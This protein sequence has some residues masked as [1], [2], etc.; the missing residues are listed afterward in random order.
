MHVTSNLAIL[1]NIK[2]AIYLC[3]DFNIKEKNL[4]VNKGE[5]K[6]WQKTDM[7]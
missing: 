7:N 3:S 1:N 5:R 6:S 2:M 4:D